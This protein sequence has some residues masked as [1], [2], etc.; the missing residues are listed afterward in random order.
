MHV[1]LSDT[2]V[3][4]KKN[5]FILLETAIAIVQSQFVKLVGKILA[6]IGA[7]RTFVTL[8]LAKMMNHP[9]L[10]QESLTELPKTATLCRGL[11]EDGRRSGH[12]WI[13]SHGS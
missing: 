12:S 8:K 1:M 13:G 5:S 4:E 11:L 10:R 2:D 7:R 9:A 3:L 6:Y